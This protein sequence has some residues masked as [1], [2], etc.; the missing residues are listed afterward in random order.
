MNELNNTSVREIIPALS[1]DDMVSF[2]DPEAWRNVSWNVGV[3]LLIP[4][5]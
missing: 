1:N 4:A 5:R 3:P 2:P